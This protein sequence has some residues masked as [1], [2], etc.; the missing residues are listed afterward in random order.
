MGDNFRKLLSIILVI[1]IGSSGAERGFFIMN[2]VRYNRRSRL[3]GFTLDALLRVTIN[4]PN[5]IEKFNA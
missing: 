5:E 4:G 3:E 1:T 2:N